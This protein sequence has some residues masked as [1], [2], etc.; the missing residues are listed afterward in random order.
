MKFQT[1]HHNKADNEKDRDQ[2]DASCRFTLSPFRRPS[3]LHERERMPPRYGPRTAV[4][5]FPRCISDPVSHITFGLC[6]S[7]PQ[8]PLVI[9]LVR[10]RNQTPANDIHL[11]CPAT[12]VNTHCLPFEIGAKF[13]S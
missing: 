4:C 11:V 5:R 13:E 3:R 6:N 10:S 1:A 12:D 7:F 8:S 9:V 2:C